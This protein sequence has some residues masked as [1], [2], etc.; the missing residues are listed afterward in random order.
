MMR[1]PEY[2][3]KM[4]KANEKLN[5]K[6]TKTSNNLYHTTSAENLESIRRD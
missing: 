6:V 5:E 4:A 2:Q 3:A 1:T